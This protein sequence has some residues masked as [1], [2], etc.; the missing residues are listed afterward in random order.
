MSK[1]KVAIIGYGYVGKAME[2]FFI[3]RYDV[4]IYDPFS[5]DV[6]SASKEEAN[7]C[8]L[9]VLCVPT[10][11]KEDA[12]CDT[13][14]VEE[15]LSWLNTPLILIKSTITPGTTEK[16][17]HKHKKRIVFSPEYMGESK[18][19]TPEHKY[20][21]PTEM[22]KHEFQIFGGSREDTEEMVQ[23]FIP[24][25]GPHVFFYQVDSTTAELIKYWEN[26]WGALKVTFVNEMYEVCKAFGVDYYKA[27]EGWLLDSRIEKMHT[28]VF[29]DSRGFGGK[30]YPKDVHALVRATEN[31][32]YSPKLIKQVLASNEEFIAKNDEQ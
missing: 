21:S 4:V 31:A 19:Y 17:I 6:V 23:W 8:G 22:V 3:R 18:Y 13:S 29:A 9:S 1:K 16:L 30:C 7:A 15:T 32:G 14:I 26:T 25:M 27:R 10:P 20:P 5:T 11:M 2:R 28:A 12:S 24:I